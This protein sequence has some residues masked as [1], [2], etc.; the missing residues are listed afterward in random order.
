M[1]NIMLFSESSS[2]K[3]RFVLKNQS[4][5]TISREASRCEHCA[6]KATVKSFSREN[7]TST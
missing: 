2:P 3:Q 6:K 5:S 4:H 7:E 1:V